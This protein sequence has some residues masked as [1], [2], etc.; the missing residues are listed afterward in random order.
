M[1]KITENVVLDFLAFLKEDLPE[2]LRL[3]ELPTLIESWDRYITLHPPE[4]TKGP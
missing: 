1:K 3:V 4:E 2:G